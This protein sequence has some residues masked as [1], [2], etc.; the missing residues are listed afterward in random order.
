MMD[1]SMI[2]VVASFSR[3]LAEADIGIFVL[4]TFDTDHLLIKKDKNKAVAALRAS[5]HAVE[6]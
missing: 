6:L 1:F 4:T 2:D 5:G 3:P